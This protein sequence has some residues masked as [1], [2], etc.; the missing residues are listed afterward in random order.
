MSRV[1]PVTVSDSAWKRLSSHAGKHD[2]TVGQMVANAVAA[3]LAPER[4]PTPSPAKPEAVRLPERP[5][6]VEPVR[7]LSKLARRRSLVG[8]A[9]EAG[10]TDRE[11]AVA[12]DKQDPDDGWTATRVAGIRR[13]LGLP[14]HKPSR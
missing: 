2:L 12:F 5:Q 8:A 10:W 13:R 4:P 11:M 14:A 1:I 7:E 9:H 3:L 6:R